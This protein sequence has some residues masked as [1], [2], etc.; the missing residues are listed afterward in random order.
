MNK[1][2]FFKDNLY[3]SEK[4]I[5]NN[6][7]KKINNLYTNKSLSNNHNCNNNHETPYN[8]SNKHY[9]RFNNIFNNEEKEKINKNFSIDLPEYSGSYLSNLNDYS[10]HENHCNTPYNMLSNN[11][12]ISKLSILS[13][14]SHLFCKDVINNDNPALF[15]KVYD[16]N[17]NKDGFKKQNN[18]FSNYANVHKG[19]YFTRELEPNINN[20]NKGNYTPSK[21]INLKD[22]FLSFSS[23]K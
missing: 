20:G 12:N 19:R 11:K 21:K 10:I 9:G 6:F 8:I 23:K 7:Y 15:F 1:D 3:T 5:N 17:I 14:Q 13:K 18:I 2:E 4:I 16:Y 22:S